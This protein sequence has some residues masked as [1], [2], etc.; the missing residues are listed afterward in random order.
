[1]WSLREEVSAALAVKA[2]N[3]RAASVHPAM[4]TSPA[5]KVASTASA[6]TVTVPAGMT[7]PAVVETGHALPHPQLKKAALLRTSFIKIYRGRP[8][9]GPALLLFPEP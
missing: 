7:V 4:M 8:S 1:M 6:E 9:S 5:A 2:A 3:A